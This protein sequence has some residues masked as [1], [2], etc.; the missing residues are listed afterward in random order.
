LAGVAN[1]VLSHRWEHVNDPERALQAARTMLASFEGH[2]LPLMCALAHGRIGELC[3]QVDPGEPAYRH[4]KAALSVAEQLGWSIATRGTWALVLANLQRGAYDEAER[5]LDEAARG[6]GDEPTG[7]AMFDTCARAEIRLGRGDVDGGLRL[8]RRAADVVVPTD[9]GG[10]WP[11]EVQ[12]V[13][14]I[15]HARFGRL[16]LVEKNV[17][18]LPGLLK[19]TLATAPV[20]QFPV[21][22]S[23]LAA[24]GLA[25]HEVRMIA[26]A[27]RF[28]LLRGFQPTMSAERIR[29]VA[30]GPAYDDAVA[31]GPAYDD[32]V[33]AYA[34]LDHDGLRKAALDLLTGWD[35]A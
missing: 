9:G 12:A 29:A 16:D 13:A 26:L 10:M 14:V 5:G 28:G 8:W 21:C 7:L 11:L 35:P 34:G 3:L 17:D 27:E 19:A 4:L 1:Y 15:T 33:A 23:L 32:A 25:T 2:D 30:G 31:G 6:A 18:A 22:G 20:M 24:L